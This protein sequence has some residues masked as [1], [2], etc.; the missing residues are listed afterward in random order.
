MAFEKGKPKTGGRR[1]GVTN[2][3]TAAAREAIGMFVDNNAERLQGWLDRVADGEKDESGN[4]VVPPNP[5]KAFTLFQSV[6]EYHIPKLARTENTHHHDG[7]LPLIKVEF[8]NGN[9]GQVSKEG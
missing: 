4:Y 9:K 8:V 1:P 2:K 5:E 6:V 7:D 3:A